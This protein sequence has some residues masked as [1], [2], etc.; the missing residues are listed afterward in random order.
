MFLKYSKKF[1]DSKTCRFQYK[2]I[3]T[4]CLKIKTT[5]SSTSNS[6]IIKIYIKYIFDNYILFYIYYKYVLFYIYYK[7]IL[8]HIY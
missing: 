2:N 8:F 7:Y 1:S 6:N 4:E 3:F 5:G